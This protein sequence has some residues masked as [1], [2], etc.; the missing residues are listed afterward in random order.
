MVLHLF[1]EV[2]EFVFV[3]VVSFIY[4]CSLLFFDEH[5]HS[6]YIVIVTEVEAGQLKNKHKL[7]C[8]T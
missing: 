6:Q 8:I 4:F 5:L 1:L 3:V 7:I 2:W